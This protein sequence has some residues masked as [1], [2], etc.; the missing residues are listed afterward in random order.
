MSKE[1]FEAVV[2]NWFEAVEA[3][4]GLPVEQIEEARRYIDAEYGDKETPFEYPGQYLA[5]R[6]FFMTCMDMRDKASDDEIWAS[7]LWMALAS[8]E[9]GYRM[10]YA[11]GLA[12][13]QEQGKEKP[14]EDTTEA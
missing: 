9:K 8:T 12:A 13:A 4:L 7:P 11:H 6:A 2:A 3:Q 14:N 10:G 5:L 1:W